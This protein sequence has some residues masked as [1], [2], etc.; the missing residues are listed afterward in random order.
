MSKASILIFAAFATLLSSCGDES[1]T[2]PEKDRYCSGDGKTYSSDESFSYECPDVWCEYTGTLMTHWSYNKGFC[3]PQVSTPNS[4]SSAIV[5]SSSRPRSSS[6]VR[7]RSSSAT[8]S[9]WYM[10]RCSDKYKFVLEATMKT[11]AC[12]GLGEQRCAEIVA[13]EVGC[14]L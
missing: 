3:K 11:A 7:P 14:T 6:S 2:N 4:S 13:E 8:C 12:A 5:S 9:P 1:P 10:C